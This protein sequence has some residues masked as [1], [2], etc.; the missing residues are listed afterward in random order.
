GF[1]LCRRYVYK[2]ISSYINDPNNNLWI[3]QRVV[4]YGNQTRY[5][6]RGNQPPNYRASR[7]AIRGLMRPGALDCLSMFKLPFAIKKSK[8]SLKLE[9]L[10]RFFLRCENHPMTS[11]A[12][13]EARESVR[14]LL[15]KNHPVPTP[16]FRAGGP[17]NPL[18]SP[19]L[20]PLHYLPVYPSCTIK[21]NSSY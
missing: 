19:Q 20:L 11:P 7:A 18:G 1:L 12:L 13:G 21:L 15:T 4:P 6:L 3:T 14:L 2:H 10:L 16:A 17:V 9:E 5:T 8:S